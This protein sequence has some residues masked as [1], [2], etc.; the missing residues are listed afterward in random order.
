M[1]DLKD[2]IYEASKPQ[3]KAA[4]FE[5]I[6]GKDLYSELVKGIQK[7]FEK[8]IKNGW[9][10]L[11]ANYDEFMKGVDGNKVNPK[12]TLLIA[13]W[14]RVDHD[15][16]K[17]W[18]W[19]GKR[20]IVTDEVLDLLTKLFETYWDKPVISGV[21]Q[22]TREYGVVPS[23]NNHWLQFKFPDGTKLHTNLSFGSL[24]KLLKY[25][26]EKNYKDYNIPKEWMK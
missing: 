19:D 20:N 16:I 21:R 10:S 1:K 24:P 14:G 22:T 25:A 6:P 26:T 9:T 4:K 17:Q 7:A 15:N 23:G 12:A 2:A 3:L 11:Q 18:K 8:D 5:N 13:T